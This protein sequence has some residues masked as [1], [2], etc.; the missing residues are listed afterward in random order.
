MKGSVTHT[1]VALLEAK[2]S[3]HVQHKSIF[4]SLSKSFAYKPFSVSFHFLIVFLFLI[5]TLEKHSRILHLTTEISEIEN[6][7]IWMTIY[8]NCWNTFFQKIIISTI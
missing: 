5:H 1:Y 2:S 8:I 4:K 3:S 7:Y 6:D